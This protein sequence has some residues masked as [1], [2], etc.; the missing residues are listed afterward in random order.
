MAKLENAQVE[1]ALGRLAGWSRTGDEI[2]KTFQ[3]ADFAEAMIFVNKV[4][5]VAEAADHHPDIDIRYNKVTIGL[6]T[7]S[8]GGITQKDVDLAGEIEALA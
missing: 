1:A 5:E 6:S 8:E 7:H 4:A 3:F 2:G